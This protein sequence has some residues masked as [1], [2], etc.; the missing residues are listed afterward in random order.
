MTM[1]N[2]TARAYLVTVHLIRQLY[3]DRPCLEACRPHLGPQLL[4]CIFTAQSTSAAESN[5]A[6]VRHVED[7]M[8]RSHD[9]CCRWAGGGAAWGCGRHRGA[10]WCARCARPGLR[11][12]A[13]HRPPT[14]CTAEA[15]RSPWRWPRLMPLGVLLCPSALPRNST[16]ARLQTSH[17]STHCR[18]ASCACSSFRRILKPSCAVRALPSQLRA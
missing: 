16:L 3:R 5:S 7:L 11:P 14:A 13:R 17:N 2:R 6:W 15:L 18:I 4:A 1:K 9:T 12:A 10:A 8:A